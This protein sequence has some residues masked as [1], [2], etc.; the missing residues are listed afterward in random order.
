MAQ[1]VDNCAQDGDSRVVELMA[2]SLNL[3]KSA[4]VV[5]CREYCTVSPSAQDQRVG[6][7]KHWWRVNNDQVVKLT[8]V[9]DE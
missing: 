2:G 5:A 8:K 1:A 4:L 3:M 6:N 9:G 7:G